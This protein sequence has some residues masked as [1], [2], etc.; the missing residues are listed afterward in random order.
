M[1]VLEDSKVFARSAA[2]TFVINM[3]CAVF[4]R[5]DSQVYPDPVSRG[6]N[7]AAAQLILA[8]FAHGM[9]DCMIARGRILREDQQ[10]LWYSGQ[11]LQA[12][13]GVALMGYMS[14]TI[15]NKNAAYMGMNTFQ[16]VGWLVLNA[17][18]L[19]SLY[20]CSGRRQQQANNADEAPLSPRS[21][22][23]ASSMSVSSDGSDND[24]HTRILIMANPV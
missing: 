5:T 20:V 12:L 21:D 1:A 7:S 23:S 22:A 16:A 2:L 18:C 10:D 17:A 24:D 3:C 9:I 15:A 8:A 11:V 6:L 19:L 14:A 13:L 4:A